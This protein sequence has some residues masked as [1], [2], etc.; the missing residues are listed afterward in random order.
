[1]S[2]TRIGLALGGGGARGMAH[3]PIL[4]AL[5]E[6]SLQ[7]VAISGTSIGAILGAG[8]A[9]GHSA[10][11]IRDYAVHT[12]KDRG[13]VLA[14]MWKLRPKRFSDFMA[15]GVLSRFDA[16]RVIDLFVGDM[17][18]EHFD[19]LKIPFSAIATDF[20]NCREVDIRSGNLRD[21]IAASIAIPALF[22]P[23]HFEDRIMIDG[24]IVNP[25]PFDVL[26]ANLDLVIAVDV[27][28][29]PIPNKRRRLP[30][31]GE[32]I[33]GATQIF[34]Q[35]IASAKLKFRQPDILMKPDIPG[36]RVLDFLKTEKIVKAAEPMKDQLKRKLDTAL[37]A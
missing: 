5:D 3:I 13:K 28:G 31:A 27:V 34:M 14:K 1:M 17:V 8:Y 23:V 10:A 19:A 11:E 9:A 24:G 35:S 33:F 15:G 25:L 30:T 26:P 12:F 7:P 2:K 29:S 18:P 32:S 21:A 16:H 37:A 6:M 4:E 20:Y 22:R 36:F